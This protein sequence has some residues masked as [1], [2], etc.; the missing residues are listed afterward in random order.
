M[1]NVT[2]LSTLP[3]SFTTIGDVWFVNATPKTLTNNYDVSVASFVDSLSVSGQE[4]E[5]HG[6]AFNNDGT[7]LYVIGASGDDVNEYNLSVAYDVSNASFSQIFSVSAQDSLPTGVAFNNDGTKMY[8]TGFTNNNVSEYTLS[9]PFDVSSANF[10]D[11]FDVSTQETQPQ[12]MAF[13]N[14][15]TKM[16]ILG[17]VGDDINEYDLSPAFDVSTGV[18][19]DTLP[20]GS[21][22]T[23]PYGIAFNND[24]TKLYLV[25]DLTDNVAQYTLSTPFDVSTG[26]IIY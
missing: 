16:Y 5:P 7:K 21:V 8:V 25:G 6:M 26:V 15:G 17:S 22:E 13:N 3:S 10:V 23:I 9:T 4:A 19:V 20:V 18:F 1:G 12:E 24:G 2:S 14:D 11:A